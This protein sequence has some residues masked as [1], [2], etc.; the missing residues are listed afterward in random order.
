MKKMIVG[1]VMVVGAATATA[2]EPENR[3]LKFAAL[4]D[5]SYLDGAKDEPELYR[6]AHE[7]FFALGQIS[8]TVFVVGMQGG[9][10]LSRDIGERDFFRLCIPE[11]GLSV[12]AVIRAIQLFLTTEQGDKFVAIKWETDPVRLL[13]LASLHRSFPWTGCQA[14]GRPDSTPKVKP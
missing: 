6:R 14:V 12:E 1:L 13:I 5:S 2:N 9:Y 3:V 8:G 7:H 11:S 4:L 10:F